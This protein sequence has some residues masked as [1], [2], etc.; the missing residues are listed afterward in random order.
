MSNSSGA[1]LSLIG[2]FFPPDLS[3]NYLKATL[4]PLFQTV[5]MAIGGMLV[6]LAI[7]LP[8][9]MVVGSRVRGG[10]VLHGALTAARAIPDLTLA[11]LC[12]VVFGLGPAA[13][14]LA[15][16]IFYTAMIGKVYA[17]LFLGASR[18]PLE[19]LH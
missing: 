19:A 12:V 8:M 4:E 6:A 2:E 14:M 15:L 7:G 3:W 13:G 18:A 1:A 5:G 10:R 11:I 9:A 17:D 16:A